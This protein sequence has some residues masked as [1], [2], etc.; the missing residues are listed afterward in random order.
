MRFR[1][2][3]RTGLAIVLLAALVSRAV[4]KVTVNR[5]EGEQATPQ[6]KFK[7]VPSPV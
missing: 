6:F 1:M 4:V 3:V 5:N 2:P 7:D